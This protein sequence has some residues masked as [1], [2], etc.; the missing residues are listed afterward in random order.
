MLAVL[1]NHLLIYQMKNLL[2]LLLTLSLSVTLRSQRILK[3]ELVFKG[4]VI[5]ECKCQLESTD[6][7]NRV[8][9]FNAQRSITATYI[10]Y[11]TAADGGI[12]ENEKVKVL[13]F[14]V[15][16]TVLQA[17]KVKQNVIIKVEEIKQKK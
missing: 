2:L 5:K 1:L 6:R 10:F 15:S 8:Y 4:A 13:W 11:T 17:G 14:L 12:K 3:A 7:R 16:Y 9:T